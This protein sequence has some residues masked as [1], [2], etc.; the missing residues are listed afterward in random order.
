ML[1]AETGD[2]RKLRKDIRMADKFTLGANSFRG[3]EYG[4]IGP[5]DSRTDD[6]LGGTR[7][8][9]STV[10]VVFPLGLPSEFGIS[11]AV[12]S[13]I[14]SVWRVGAKKDDPLKP[15]TTRA[16]LYDDH[17]IRASVGAGVSWDSPFGPISIDYARTVRRQKRDVEQ[18]I[19]FGFTTRV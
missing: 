18:R 1:K 6:S 11:G 19:L 3:F 8:W 17:K 5:R 14:G 4:G 15:G 10:E 12:F 16:I 7:Y 2:L 9:T 13:D